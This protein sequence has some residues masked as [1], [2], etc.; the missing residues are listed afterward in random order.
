MRQITGSRRVIAVFILIF[1]VLTLWT[2]H[3]YLHRSKMTDHSTP[4][5]VEKGVVI[6]D[7]SDTVRD[8][9]K[10]GP[11]EAASR[12]HEH[13]VP[14]FIRSDERTTVE[15]FPPVTGRIVETSLLA[16]QPVSRGQ[17][18]AVMESS[19]FN[20]ALADYRSAIAQETYQERVVTRARNVLKVGGNAAKDLDGALNALA[21]AQAERQRA[22]RRLKALN[23]GPDQ[24]TSGQ[25]KILSPIDGNVQRTILAQG[26]N[27]TDA[28]ISQATLEDL[29]LVQIE[30]YVPEDAVATIRT[31]LP[32]HVTFD[33]LPGRVCDGTVERI[34]PELRDEIR[35]IIAR[36][37]CPNPDRVLRPNMFAHARIDIPMPP[38][39]LIP[40]SSVVM[41]NDQLIVFVKVAEGRYARRFIEASFDE[42]DHVRVRKGLKPD[43]I[44]VTQGA[45]LLNDA[46]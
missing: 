36:M 18:L 7:D 46:V 19:D 43:D 42:T 34:D 17:V 31:G 1:I 28:T 2:L 22:E 6:L 40:K 16:G 13:D 45:I 14:A 24:V 39:L 10:T 30:A 23:I 41:N 44:I 20:Q 9:I 21:Q 3:S 5:R 27:I 38:M 32:M 37:T 29:S 8:Q 33:D 25:V 15:V 12:L 4:I 35:R 26:K 11:V